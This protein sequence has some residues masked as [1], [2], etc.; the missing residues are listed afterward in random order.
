MP[1]TSSPTPLL[2]RSLLLLFLASF[3]AMTSFY[4]LLSVVPLYTT[5]SGAGDAG[6]GLATGAM[7]LATVAAELATPTLLARFGYRLVLA[8]GLVLLGVPALA[9]TA[10]ATLAGILV[11]S[12]ARGVGLA[13]FVVTGSALVALLVPRERRPEGLGVFGIVVGVPAIVALPLGVWLVERVG[14]P[15]VFVAGAVASLVGLVSVPVLPG[16]QARPA[17][18]VGVLAGLRT[19]AQLRPAM[20]FLFTAVGA[21]VVVTFLPLTA[22]ASGGLVVMALFA[23]SASTTLARWWAGRYGG[24]YGQAALLVRGVVA[25]GIGML[26]LVLV[27]SAAA[28]VIGTL[29]LGGGF[30]VAQNASLALM[31]DRVS[32]EGY[33][34]VSAVW[35]LAY[36]AGMGLG[37]IGFGVI[38]SRTGYAAAFG[39]TGTLMLLALAPVWLRRT[40]LAPVEEPAFDA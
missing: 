39:L 3:G 11:V 32:A 19:A 22:G 29:L 38:A 15:A 17:Q 36:D 6:A 4:L 16:R 27:G 12:A 20:L 23:H 33:D 30:G 9:L 26:A 5:S 13:I 35:N 1:S 31:F 24:R 2:S 8:V 21:G 37:A 25:A 7:M 40:W 34:M 18:P 14:F 28:L 10:S